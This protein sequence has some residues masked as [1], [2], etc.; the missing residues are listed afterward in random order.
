MK[1]L[2]VVARLNYCFGGFTIA[3]NKAHRLNE[4]ITVPEIRLQGVDGEQLGVM[5]IRA[6]LQPA[7][8]A[9]SISLRLHHSQTR[10]FVA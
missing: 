3:Q 9:E 6:A 10:R 2:R 1:L 5:N 4:E 8:E 7:E